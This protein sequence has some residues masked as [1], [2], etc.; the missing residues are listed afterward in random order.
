[1][2]LALL[3]ERAEAYA[4]SVPKETATLG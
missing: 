1:L 3:R 2:S 4:M